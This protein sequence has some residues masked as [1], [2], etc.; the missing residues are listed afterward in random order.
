MFWFPQFSNQLDR[1]KKEIYEMMY[2]KMFEYEINTETYNKPKR[3]RFYNFIR[4][5]KT[6]SNRRSYKLFLFLQM[7]G[8]L[9][10]TCINYFLN[11]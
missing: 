6:Y 2:G 1:T 10:S 5:F 4:Q 11:Q 3:K 7:K 9:I 8:K